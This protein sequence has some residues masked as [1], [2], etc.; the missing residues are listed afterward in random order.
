MTRQDGKP[1]ATN[2]RLYTVLISTHKTQPT[3]CASNKMTR[4][5]AN[6]PVVVAAV[7]W[8]VFGFAANKNNHVQAADTIGEH[9]VHVLGQEETEPTWQASPEN[10]NIITHNL[11]QDLSQPVPC[12]H[13]KNQEDKD[14]MLVPMPGYNGFQAYK[15]ADISSFYQELPGSRVE[16]V[17][18]FIGQ[19]GKFV[20]M[21]SERLDLYWYVCQFDARKNPLECR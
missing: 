5:L 18:D 9:Q 16:T 10:D 21:A 4:R 20:N 2:M 15:R 7:S 13:V 11:T 19:A 12:P 6:S 14:P 3:F 17:P 8:L 1:I